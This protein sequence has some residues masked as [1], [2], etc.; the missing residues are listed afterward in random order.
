MSSTKSSTRPTDRSHPVKRHRP[1]PSGQVFLPVAYA[2]WIGLGILGLTMAAALN[3]PFFYALLFLLVMGCVYNIA[4]AVQGP[5][6][7]GCALGVGQ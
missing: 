3:G 6:V 1:V 4:G 5:A 7:C 2:E